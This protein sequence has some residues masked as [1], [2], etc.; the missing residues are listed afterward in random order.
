MN[1]HVYTDTKRHIAMIVKQGPNC[2][3]YQGS[4]PWSILHN[5]GLIDKCV[6][7][8]N[9]RQACAAT[10]PECSFSRS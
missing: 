1:I 9:A 8:E 2:I 7:L 3:G 10:Y 4:Y 5:T 6:S